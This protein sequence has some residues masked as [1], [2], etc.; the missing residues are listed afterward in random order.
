MLRVLDGC[1]RVRMAIFY[2][3]IWGLCVEKCRTIYVEKVQILSNYNI[4]TYHRRRNIMVYRL[5]NVYKLYF[6]EWT[7]SVKNSYRK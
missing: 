6:R 3:K 1:V 7:E 5:V 4:E 2:G